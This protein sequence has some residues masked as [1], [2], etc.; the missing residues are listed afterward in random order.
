MQQCL[1]TAEQHPPDISFEDEDAPEVWR[2]FVL[3]QLIPSLWDSPEGAVAALEAEAA[4]WAG[5]CGDADGKAE[6]RAVTDAL[7]KGGPLDQ[8]SMLRARVQRE[9]DRDRA[10][11]AKLQQQMLVDDDDEAGVPEMDA[12]LA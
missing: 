1:P 5:I 4:K 9:G 3:D 7:S 12:D 11:Y 8:I 2:R 6:E 10:T